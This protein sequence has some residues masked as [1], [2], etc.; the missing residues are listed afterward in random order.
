MVIARK[1]DFFLTAAKHL[2]FAGKK[3]HF[4]ALLIYVHAMVPK[5]SDSKGFI[6]QPEVEM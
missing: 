4:A 2:I 5:Y 3:E 6:S 1:G